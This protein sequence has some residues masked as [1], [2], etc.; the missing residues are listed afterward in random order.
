MLAVLMH[1]LD[2]EFQKM[3]PLPDN[4]SVLQVG[5]KQTHHLNRQNDVMF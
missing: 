5:G 1:T 2:H 3:M 4:S